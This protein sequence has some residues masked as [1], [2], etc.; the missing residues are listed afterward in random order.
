MS[1]EAALNVDIDVEVPMRDGTILRANV[2]RP[3]GDGRW[4]VL[5]TRLPYG[6][7]L[8]LGTAVADPVQAA[9]R[10]YAV[11]VQ[12]TRG[13]FR[14]DGEWDPFRNEAAD[15]VDTI[16]WAAVQSWSNGEVGMFGASYFGFTQWAAAVQA[17]PALKAISPLMTWSDPYRGVLF[18]GGAM[19]LGTA[20][21]WQA[22]MGFDVLVRRHRPDLRAMAGAIRRL[23]ATY[24]RLGTTGYW[25]LP[26]SE[27][28]AARDQNVGPS[29]FEINRHPIDRQVGEPLRIAGR[30]H[31]AKA[32]SLNTGGWF[33]IFL[34]HS[35]DAYV[36]SRAAGLP[37]RL[38]VGPWT[39][40]TLSN[41]VGEVNFGFGAQLGFIDLQSD[42]LSL[43]LR[44]FD[45][46]LKGI[47][48][49]VDAE[50]P[51]R[52]FV[53]GANVWRYEPEWPLERAVAS[54]LFLRAG[55][56]LDAGAPG[57]EAPDAYAYDP[58][59]PVLTLGGATLMT[60]EFPSGPYD[61]RRVE[62]RP[63]VLTYTTEP[64]ERDLEVTG[65]VKVVLW[66]ISDAPDTDFV[67]RLCEVASDGRS[68]NLTD[69]IVRARYRDFAKGG[70]PSL[71]EPGRPYE[72]EIDLWSTSNLFRAGNRIRLQVTSS[73]FP[74]W[75]RN[76]NTGHDLEADTELRVANQQILHD[77]EHPSRLVISVV[78]A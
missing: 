37:T 13:R 76:L 21:A 58:A 42:F 43:Q 69:G 3:A 30:H 23:G 17:P 8:P 25:W 36:A 50:A 27:F 19:E 4:P 18:R 68:I 61:Q 20:G 48:A 26:L 1:G 16:A 15:G 35:I 66:A 67:A 75:D 14:S 31:E 24:D 74:R 56:R 51:V 49:G 5:L 62:C 64:L 11:V 55:G 63:D 41:P 32:A 53:M 34:Q 78:P 7:D 2:Y 60:P 52:I 22:Q 10:G 72:Y 38:I 47:D 29:F 71:I 65:P 12:D 54:E 9:R 6:K 44:W 57:A 59:D 77:R 45:R 70:V 39:H 28:E 40:S 33:D 73:N 46:W